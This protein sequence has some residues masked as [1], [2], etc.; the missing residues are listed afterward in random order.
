MLAL[1]T[2]FLSWLALERRASPLTVQAYGR[3]LGVLQAFLTQHLGE[4]P[5][6]HASRSLDG[7]R[8][9]SVACGGRGRGQGQSD[10][11]AASFGV[12]Q[13][14][15]LFGAAARRGERGGVADRHA[16]GDPA[17]AA[18][19]LA[20][21]CAHCCRG[22]GDASALASTQARD[23]ALFT[24]LYGCGLRIAEALAL[25]VRDAPQA[26]Q[27]LRVLGKGSKQRLVPVLPAVAEAVAAWLVHHPARGDSASPLFVGV[28]GGRLN[29]AWRNAPCGISGGWPGCRNT[30]RRIRCAIRLPRIC[31]PAARICARS[32]ICWGMRAWRQ[33]SITRRWTRRSCCGSGGRPT[34]RVSRERRPLV[35]R[36]RAAA[37]GREAGRPCRAASA[38]RCRI[39]QVM[40]RADRACR[41]GG[42]APAP[43]PRSFC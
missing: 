25:S 31:W 30:R 7:E 27:S 20:G 35:W 22:G 2:G 10:A 23:V 39:G 38:R 40:C 24:L 43:S 9:A 41:T 1:L 29:R 5:H 32:R 6:T 21:G 36:A 17:G 3:D 37:P 15:P 16:A 14:L 12:A 19:A 18:C 33:R 34:H 13:F 26:G 4:E 28:R 42:P 8:F 11:G